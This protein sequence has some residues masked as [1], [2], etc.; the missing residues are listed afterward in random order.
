MAEGDRRPD[1]SAVPRGAEGISLHMTTLGQ[2]SKIQ[3]VI[4]SFALRRLR[5]IVNTIKNYFTS[6]IPRWER[7][8]HP[9]P[10]QRGL[11]INS[12]LNDNKY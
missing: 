12:I 7:I 3:Y 1:Y 2:E 6:I 4:H 9:K 8:Q 5:D 11:F 10:R